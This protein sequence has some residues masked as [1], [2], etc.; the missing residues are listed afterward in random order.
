MRVVRVPACLALAALSGAFAQTPDT[1]P[2]RSAEALVA[3]YRTALQL[4]DTAGIERLFYW[5]RAT[6]EARRSVHTAIGRDFA[7]VARSVSVEP[8]DPLPLTEFTRDGVTYH[9][10]LPP[11]ARLVVD[12]EPPPGGH[13]TRDQTVYYIGTRAGAYYLITSEPKPK[14]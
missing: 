7:H 9:M 12:F 4:H 6:A 14:P 13:V 5:G 1:A 10:T 11:I 2:P 8:M 3:R